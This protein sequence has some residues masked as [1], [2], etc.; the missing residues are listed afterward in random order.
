MRERLVPGD[1]DLSCLAHLGLLLLEGPQVFLWVRP[2]P[3]SN[4]QTEMRWTVMPWRSANSPGRSFKVRSC[5]SAIRL[6]IAALTAPSLPWP[7]ASRSKMAMALTNFT[8]T[9]NV[10][11][12]HVKIPLLD[13]SN[14]PLAKRHRK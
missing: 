3:R 8:N 9:R 4:R 12:L 14:H 6:A 10:P 5:F 2:G 13:A 11:L 7:P 1:P